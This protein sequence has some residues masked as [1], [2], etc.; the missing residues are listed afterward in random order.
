[1][2][3]EF[4]GNGVLHDAY[5]REILVLAGQNDVPDQTDVQ[6]GGTVYDV[7]GRRQVVLMDQS[8]NQIVDGPAVALDS[9]RTLGSLAAPATGTTPINFADSNGIKQRSLYVKLFLGA[10][11]N[12]SVINL[13]AG[14]PSSAFIEVQQVGGPWGVSFKGTVKTP[15]GTGTA[16][17]GTPNA[18]DTIVVW[19]PDGSALRA[20]VNLNYS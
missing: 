2:P 6:G 1:M 13:A 7:E 18:L 20:H 11:I 5:G 12:L 15:G 10:T 17:S 14:V 4:R 19:T 16:L 9:L 3:G 8:L